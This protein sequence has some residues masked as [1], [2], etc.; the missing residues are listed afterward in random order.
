MASVGSKRVK[1]S[2]N[3]EALIIVSL[4]GLVALSESVLSDS[5]DVSINWTSE[6]VLGKEFECAIK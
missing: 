4:F 5:S 6:I 3:F 1:N 2:V